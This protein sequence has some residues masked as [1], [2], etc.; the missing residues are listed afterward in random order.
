MHKCIKATKNKICKRL[1]HVNPFN[2]GLQLDLTGEK[3]QVSS[4]GSIYR[5]NPL[6]LPSPI[7][8]YKITNI[9]E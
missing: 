6:M 7:K 4:V 2:T 5:V 9:T 8:H 3:F 1:R